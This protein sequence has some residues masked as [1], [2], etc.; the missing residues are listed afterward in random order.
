MNPL[1][2]DLG[3]PVGLRPAY[4]IEFLNEK[5]KSVKWIEVISENIC[6]GREKDLGQ[7]YRNFNTSKQD[8]PAVLS[9][10]FNEFGFY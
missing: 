5:P 4:H 1:I 10:C 8:Y 7:D 3:K 9:W 6:L 2:L